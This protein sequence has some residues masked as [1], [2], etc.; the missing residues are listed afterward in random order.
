M[1]TA[2]Y[3]K[4]VNKCILK[5]CVCVPTSVKCV[6]FCDTAHQCAINGVYLV[7]FMCISRR[8][9]FRHLFEEVI[10]QHCSQFSLNLCATKLD[11]G[12]KN[13]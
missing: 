5:R 9:Q 6:T 11:L 8:S 12:F 13:G 7:V 3:L 1:V 2:F 10:L 4:A